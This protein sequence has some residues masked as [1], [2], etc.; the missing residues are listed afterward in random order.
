MTKVHKT[1]VSKITLKWGLTLPLGTA[2]H[3]YEESHKVKFP[4]PLPI[5][6]LFKK[7]QVDIPPMCLGNLNCEKHATYVHIAHLEPLS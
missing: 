1:I 6:L 4:A 3:C 7:R 2:L 5:V